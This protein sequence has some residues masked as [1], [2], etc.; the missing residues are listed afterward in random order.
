[1]LLTLGTFLMNFYCFRLTKSLSCLPVRDFRGSSIAARDASE[2]IVCD[3]VEVTPPVATALVNK[4]LD[5]V[6]LPT[7]RRLLKLPT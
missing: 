7:L 6:C 2:F 5:L 4:L 3:V 1:M